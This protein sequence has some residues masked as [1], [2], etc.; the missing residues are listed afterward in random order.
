MT[1][2]LKID[3]EKSKDMNGI[4]I[5]NTSSQTLRMLFMMVITKKRGTRGGGKVQ[6][7]RKIE[8]MTVKKIVSHAVTLQGM[9]NLVSTHTAVILEDP[10]ALVTPIKLN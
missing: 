3:T 6:Q 8:K 5:E 4:A 9:R 1:M 2:I 10:A 7:E